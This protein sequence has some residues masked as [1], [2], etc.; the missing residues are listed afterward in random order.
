MLEGFI[1]GVIGTFE[2]MILG[3]IGCEALDRYRFPLDTDVYYLDTLPVVV[4]YG[5]V[6]VVALVSVSICF[7]ATIYP[8][9]LAASMNPVEGIRYD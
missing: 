6:G 9:Y 7:A 3:L 8:A 4:D 2:G 1:I 5:T